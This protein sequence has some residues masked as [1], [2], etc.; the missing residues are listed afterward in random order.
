MSRIGY[1]TWGLGGVDYGPINEKKALNLL[2]YSYKK[3]LRFFD[4]SPLYGYGKSE[5]LIGKFLKNKVRKKIIIC[6]KC[7]MLPHSGF[8]M[9]QDFSFNKLNMDL[10]ESLGRLDTNY[11]DILLLHSPD[12]E[13]VNVDLALENLN[14]FKK[15]KKIKS[16][17]ISLRSPNEFFLVKNKKIIDYVEINFNL[18]DQRALAINFFNKL[19]RYKIK[20]ICRTPLSF[21][22]LSDKKIIKSELSKTDHRRFWSN[23]Q[24]QRWNTFKKFFSHYQTK[25]EIRNL[26]LFALKFCL[27]YNFD[28]VIPGML[29]EL[30]IRENLSITKSKKITEKDLKDIFKI[31]N[32]IEKD[33]FIQKRTR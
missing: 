31:Y 21:G 29:S 1:G 28:Y 15:L 25:Y 6:T 27:S 2:N 4:T 13:K 26:S 12:F 8:K 16:I 23:R 30:E 7:G 24:F 22:F 18:L 3:G 33:I 17:G 5:K 32:N 11:I 10:I 20:A 9:L 14:S 19:N